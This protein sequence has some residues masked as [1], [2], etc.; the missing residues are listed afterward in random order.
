MGWQSTACDTCGVFVNSPSRDI[1]TIITAWEVCFCHPAHHKDPPILFNYINTLDWGTMPQVNNC[2]W[3][4]IDCFRG[5]GSSQVWVCTAVNH[6]LN[7]SICGR[8]HG[9]SDICSW[10]SRQFLQNYFFFHFQHLSAVQL[11]NWANQT[12]LNLHRLCRL[13]RSVLKL[14]ATSLKL[15]KIVKKHFVI[16]VYFSAF[17]W[18]RPKTQF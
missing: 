15:K 17:C 13:L 5:C 18:W 9:V 1:F 11:D 4:R 16:T 14:V 10:S 12:G 2:F 8:N 7:H 3:L 6:N